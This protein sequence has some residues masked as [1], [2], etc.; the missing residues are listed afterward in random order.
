MS[1]SRKK[2]I[3]K[4]VGHRKKDYWRVHRRVNKEITKHFIDSA[5]EFVDCNYDDWEEF[6]KFKNFFIQKGIKGVKP[7]KAG[8]LLKHFFHNKWT[9]I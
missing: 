4:D 9:Y 7:E 8:A 3:V 1:R 5:R 2:A 6:F